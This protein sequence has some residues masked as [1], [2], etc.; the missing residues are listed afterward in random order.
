MNAPI[1]I[2]GITLQTERLILRP[3]HQEDLDDFF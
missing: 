1:D 3:W 2:S